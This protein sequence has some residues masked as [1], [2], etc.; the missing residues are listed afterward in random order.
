M[1]KK[2]D[3]DKDKNEA[4]I[5]TLSAEEKLGPDLIEKIAEKEWKTA[6]LP[7]EE[8]LAQ[9]KHKSPKARSNAK[10]R[11]NLT[12]YQNKK[13]KKV[14]EEIVKA[15][16][17][18]K[19][20]EVICPFDYIKLPDGYPQENVTPFLPDRKVMKD[21]E[22]EISFYKILNAFLSDFDLDELTSS[23]IEDVVSLGINRILEN[24][25]L[26]MS[27]SDPNLLMDAAATVERFRKHTDK[28]KGNLA[29]RR[30]DR[31]DPKNKQNYSIV[32][33]VYAYDDKK[34]MEF[35]ERIKAIEKEKKEYIKKKG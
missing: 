16:K 27:A 30:A 13:S 29:S 6:P 18:T 21:A 28:V 14:K 19:K 33:L 2:K 5:D 7:T 25:L 32:D 10:S 35:K 15:L 8:E 1:A 31:I 3:K 12:Q 23:D 4:I 11:Q 17:F 24:R 9:E 20:R 22:E 26:F 34:E